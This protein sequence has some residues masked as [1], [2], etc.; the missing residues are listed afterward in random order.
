MGLLCGPHDAKYLSELGLPG[1]HAAMQTSQLIDILTYAAAGG[2]L[3]FA[4]RVAAK[5]CR[6][7]Q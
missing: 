2:F 6:D 1:D 7:I 4:I 5:V 3:C